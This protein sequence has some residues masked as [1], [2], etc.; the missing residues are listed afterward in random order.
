MSSSLNNE[1]LD[2][3]NENYTD[4]LNLGKQLRGGD[5][6]V[7]EVKV[8]MLGFQR[9][10]EGL[11]Q[12]IEERRRAM[13][14]AIEEKRE[15]GK[16]IAMA[17]KL[18]EIEERIAGLEE[19]LLLSEPKRVEQNGDREIENGIE[20]E[21]DADF[22][23]EEDESSED[24]DSAMVNGEG[25]EFTHA[26]KRL[27][28]HVE[29]YQIVRKLITVWGEGHPFVEA[30]QSRFEQIRSTL[31]LDLQNLRKDASSKSSTKFTQ[32]MK[33]LDDL[34]RSHTSTEIPVR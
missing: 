24:E 14:G 20:R 29:Q 32:E 31:L 28:R 19:K 25:H 22:D 13:A 4:F 27:R 1:L 8:G 21:S 17:R 15:V 33:E 2:L 30:Q 5:E 10:V 6:K 7:E 3:V 16:E 34:L 18:L 12:G 23:S 9:E 11:K 26:F